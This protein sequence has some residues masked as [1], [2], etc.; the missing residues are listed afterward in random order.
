LTNISGVTGKTLHESL[1]CAA[2]NTQNQL[3]TC[4]T[5][6]AA[7][8]LIQNG[9][10]NYTYDAENRL[11]AASGYSYLYDGDGQRIEKCTA[12]ATPGTCAS[13]STGTFYWRLTD[14]NTQAESDLGGNWTAAYG[15]IRGQIAT[16]V[17]LTS[18]ENVVHYYYHD[19]LN[20]TNIV[21]D[22]LGNIQQESDYYP[23]GGEI[24]ITGGDSNHYKFT[25]KE[26]DAESNLDM[27]G[28]RYY[29]SSLGRFMTP[30]WA[31]KATAVPYAKFGDPQTL[32]LYSYVQNN[33]LA[34]FDDDA[35]L[36]F[37]HESLFARGH[38]LRW[39]WE[40][41]ERHVLPVHL[42]RGREEPVDQ[43]QSNVELYLRCIWP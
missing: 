43:R 12:G 29:G 1:N 41:V 17:D 2:A 14:G 27:F 24:V 25:S 37:Q 21:T 9:T 28:A 33:P 16:R 13:N 34:R 19:H 31:A 30:D 7:G 8:N 3:N 11:V 38:Q 18:G 39:K 26:R 23:Y 4:Y 15:V 10:H 20:S 6:D 40:C 5:Y 36:Q 42:G 32:N 22:Y 35:R